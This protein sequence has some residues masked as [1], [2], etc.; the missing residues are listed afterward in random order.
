MPRGIEAATFREGTIRRYDAQLGGRANH[1]DRSK[2]KLLLDGILDACSKGFRVTN[3]GSK[4]DVAALQQRLRVH[5]A[6]RFVKGAQF[7]HW[8]EMMTPNVDAAQEREV[9]G[10]E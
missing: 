5:E 3:V 2:P 10:H 6:E 8:D 9:G 4:H 1:N 7:R